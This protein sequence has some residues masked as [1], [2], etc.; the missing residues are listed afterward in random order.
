MKKIIALLTLVSVTS[1]GVYIS[2]SPDGT[3]NQGITSASRII[4][5]LFSSFVQGMIQFLSGGTQDG[6]ELI[7]TIG[8]LDQPELRNVNVASF[9]GTSSEILFTGTG[10]FSPTAVSHC[11][12]V[13]TGSTSQSTKYIFQG[14]SADASNYIRQNGSQLL[15]RH[16]GVGG[17]I[18]TFNSIFTDTN[19]HHIVISW[20]GA[21]IIIVKDGVAVGSPVAATGTLLASGFNIHRIGRS[22]TGYWLGKLSQFRIYKKGLT[23]EEAQL[24][25]Y[26]SYVP[27]DGELFADIVMGEDYA[28][29]YDLAKSITLASSS[30]GGLI[31]THTDVTLD[32]EDA[33]PSVHHSVGHSRY[34]LL[35]MSQSKLHVAVYPAQSN[36]YG[37]NELNDLPTYGPAR[38][39]DE[40]YPIGVGTSGVGRDGVFVSWWDNDITPQ[41]TPQNMRRTSGY[42]GPEIRGCAELQNQT[43][44]P[45]FVSKS[46]KGGAPLDDFIKG[47]AL[48]TAF[49]KAYNE[50][51]IANPS[52]STIDVIWWTQGESGS[53]GGSGTYQAKMEQL[54]TDMI[55]DFGHAG[56]II[57]FAGVGG[58]GIAESGDVKAINDI[59]RAYVTANPTK[60]VYFDSTDLLRMDG[61]HYYSDQQLIRGQRFADSTMSL[62]STTESTNDM[63]VAHR[64]DGSGIVEI[65]PPTNYGRVSDNPSGYVH[66]ISECSVIQ[67]D[68]SLLGSGQ[69]FWTS[70]G[71]TFDEKTYA[72]FISHYD[73][74]GVYNLWLKIEGDGLIEESVQYPL[75][76]VFTYEE[77]IQNV[78]YFGTGVATNFP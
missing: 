19:W 18:T 62:L 61:A 10:G 15:W 38:T 11:F 27:A 71:T 70:D 17:G 1:F 69:N 78:G 7:D 21:Q 31:G 75:D 12:W 9:N 29:S 20:D 72:D 48:Y 63:W 33:V 42:V 50:S 30:I 60:A 56:T 23:A 13:K 28:E 45:I 22:G 47:S 65:I 57:V 40:D 77:T 74:N 66:N 68:T 37:M 32:K 59:F 25:M 34:N 36:G 39:T 14:G 76:K 49:T 52:A 41:Y 54:I 26:N 5:P 67:T 55:T 44:R 43:G 53:V 16:N 3:V 51:N 46:V 73:T 8:T 35:T 64:I 4:Y 58:D 24:E 2:V 6:I